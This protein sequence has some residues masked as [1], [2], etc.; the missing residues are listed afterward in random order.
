MPG[1]DIPSDTEKERQFLQ[2]V[3][4]A[5]A[6]Q[7]CP[8][9]TNSARVIGP[10]C[11]PLNAPLMFIGEAPGRL[12]ADV[13]HLP[14]H[15]DKAGHNFE[16]LLNQVGLSRYDIFVTNAVLCNPKGTGGNNATPNLREQQNCQTHLRQQL[17][18]LNPRIVVTLGGTALSAVAG[19]SP[20]KLTLRD[21]VRTAVPWN[22][23]LLIPLYHPGQRALL[24]RSFANQLSDYQFVVETLSRIGKSGRTRRRAP[25]QRTSTRLAAVTQRILYKKKQLSYFALHKL[26]FLAEAKYLEETGERLTRAYIIRQKDGPYC[27]DLHPKQLPA[28]VPNIQVTS[29]RDGLMIVAPT[30]DDFFENRREDH[31]LSAAALEIIDGV[32]DRY[33]ELSHSDLK[34]VAYLASPM[35]RILRREHAAKENLFNA[36]LFP[37]T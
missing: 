37:K 12:G 9:M 7:L 8:R 27:V 17:E 33:G 5:K 29:T 31:V 6:C 4:R 26:L 20:H 10:G 36:P 35:R 21:H 24:H 2:L 32:I 1:M 25:T 19:L 11:G 14:F 28:L 30:Q 23:R 13:S 15:G 3:R 34:R 16:S 18:L 22:G